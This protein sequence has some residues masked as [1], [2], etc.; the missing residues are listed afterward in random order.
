MF[1]TLLVNKISSPVGPLH[2]LQTRRHERKCATARPLHE[3]MAVCV[4][5]VCVVRTAMEGLRESG[6]M[7]VLE[8][9]QKGETAGGSAQPA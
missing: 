1:L 9:K 6:R 3:P 5:V 7:C 8:Q 4:C 2:T